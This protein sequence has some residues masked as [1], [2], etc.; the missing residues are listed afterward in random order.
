[1]K[2]NTESC[3]NNHTIERFKPKKIN[4]PAAT[5]ARCRFSLMSFERTWTFRYLNLTDIPLK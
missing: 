5:P 2:K 4:K 3:Y 1:M